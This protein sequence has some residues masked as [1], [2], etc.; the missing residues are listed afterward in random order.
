MNEQIRHDE[1]VNWLQSSPFVL[2]HLLPLAALWTGTRWIDWMVCIGLFWLRMFFITA[3]YHRYFA[4]RTFRMGRRTQFAFAF[5]AQTSAQMGVLWWSGHHRHHHQFSDRAEDLHSPKRG[6][7]WSHCLWFLCKRYEETPEHLIRDFHR[8][9]ELRWLNRYHIVPPVVLALLVYAAL[10]TSGLLIGFFLSTALLF[11]A[12]FTI[13]SLAHIFGT[14]RYPTDDLS[15]NNWWLALLTLGEGW[16]N[17]HHHYQNSCR[18]GFFWWEIDITWW[19]LKGLERLGLIWK[20]KAPPE[21]IRFAHRA[22]TPARP[23]RGV[24]S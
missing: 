3:G 1:S 22:A 5:M 18:Q 2:I 7:W 15:R 9:P 13:N 11:H 14:R 4:H 6:F 21:R 8:Y 23:S 19:L 20:M 12:T 17:N 10:G 16:H 24:G